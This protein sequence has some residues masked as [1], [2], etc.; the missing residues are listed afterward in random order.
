[1]EE[2]EQVKEGD[3]A[4]SSSSLQFWTT[5]EE[6]AAAAT[7]SPPQRSLDVC[8]T[9]TAMAATLGSQYED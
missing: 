8:P 6:V 4:S 2:V 1:M 3:A 9:P 5:R 7:A